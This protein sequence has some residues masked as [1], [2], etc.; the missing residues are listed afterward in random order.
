MA[1]FRPAQGLDK[2]HPAH[3]ETDC[4]GTSFL[5]SLMEVVARVLAVCRFPEN[6]SPVGPNR[7]R[8]HSNVL[9]PDLGLFAMKLR[10]NPRRSHLKNVPLHAGVTSASFPH[11]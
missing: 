1:A 11:P 4:T 2:G 6:P 7:G 9:V 8:S 10:I 5:F 3:P